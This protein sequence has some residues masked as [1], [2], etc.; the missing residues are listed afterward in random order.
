MNNKKIT[1]KVYVGCADD[2]GE[3]N[4]TFVRR[5]CDNK[6]ITPSF[7]N[8]KELEE[9]LN[10]INFIDKKILIANMLGH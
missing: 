5:K 9:W 2:L 8:Y 1:A 7:N 3:P 4:K 10:R 6:Q